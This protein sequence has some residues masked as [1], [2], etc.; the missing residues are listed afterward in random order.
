LIRKKSLECSSDGDS[1]FSA[2]FARVTLYHPGLDKP[3]TRSIEEWYQLSKRFGKI[4]PRTAKDGKGK[5][6]THLMIH[7]VR[8]P[9]HY[10]SQWYKLLWL[11]YLDES[12]GLVKFASQFDEFT[13]KFR[14]RRAGNCQADVVRQYIKR[15]RNSIIEDCEPLLKLIDRWEEFN[16][17]KKTNVLPKVTAWTDG[18]CLSNGLPNAIGGWAYIIEHEGQEVEKSFAD[19]MRGTTCNKME[20]RAVIAIFKRLKCPCDITVYTDSEYVDRAFNEDRLKRWQ[21]NGWRT[22][23]RKPV[24]NKL[25]WLELLQAIK[26]GGHTI[27]VV[28]KDE[29][30]EENIKRCHDMATTATK[31]V[32]KEYAA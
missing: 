20:L 31:R 13:D 6:P 12:P 25:M 28:Y 23:N 29:T 7:G 10:L 18:S 11:K 22:Q 24:A 1:R 8:Y 27:S 4:K 21:K 30:E 14:G 26:D 5:S 15:G 3:V 2:F 32:K 17:V 9:K 16:V 19:R